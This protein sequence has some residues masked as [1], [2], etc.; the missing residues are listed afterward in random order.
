MAI[1]TDGGDDLDS[2]VDSDVGDGGG[3][4]GTNHERQA[5]WTHTLVKCPKSLFVLWQEYEFGLGGRIPAK[6]F[7]SKDRGRVKYK[8]CMRKHFWDLISKMIQHGYSHTS[9]I[10]KV[11]TIYDGSV[12]NILRD[13]RKDKKRGGHPQLRF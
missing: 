8:Y 5:D 11:Y 10:D 9:A 12:T 13:I 3:R 2:D 1:R 4:G 6:H 7:N